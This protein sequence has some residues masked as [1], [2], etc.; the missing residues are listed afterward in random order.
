MNLPEDQA[1][2]IDQQLDRLFEKLEEFDDRCLFRSARQVATEISRLARSE[3]RLL[4]YLRS[5]F[6]LMNLAQST[7]EPELGRDVALELIALLESEERARQFQPNFPEAGYFE[8][9]AW[10]SACAYDNLAKHTATIQGYNSEGMHSCIGE[11]IQV[12]RRTGKLRCIT[13]FREYATDVYQ[14]ADD[15]DMALHYARL[16]ASLPKDAPGSERRWVGAKDET[17]LLTLSAQLP[18]AEAAGR[19]ALTLAESYH[20][21]LSAQLETLVLLETIFLL[22]GKYDRFTSEI[23]V[24]PSTRELP[25]GE[26]P[27]QEVSWDQ[28]DALLACCRGDYNE[29]I[30]L[31]SHWDRWLNERHCQ[32]DWF[33]IRLRLI[34]TFRL[35]GQDGKLDALA[36]LLETR[37]RKAC[38]WLTLRRLERLLDPNE[39]AT[40]LAL[41]APLTRGPFA[42][43]GRPAE[44]SA[45]TPAPAGPDQPPETQPQPT[46]L[47]E[48][49]SE[50]A[51]RLDQAGEDESARAAILDDFLALDSAAVTHPLDAARLLHLVRYTLGDYQRGEE[52]W[53]W[54]Q[55]I[56]APFAQQPTVVSLLATL[57]DM[58]RSGPNELL[59]TQI[60]PTRLEQL[61]RQSLDL[62]K[63]DPGNYARAGLFYLGQED[64]GE[65]ERCL[66]RSFRLVRSNGPIALRLAEVYKQTDRPR[67]ALAVLDLCL[68]EGSEDAQVA[69]D[70]ALIAFH[71]EQYDALLTYLDRFEQLDPGQPWTNYYRATGLLEVGK[72]EEA[73]KALDEEERR[74]PDCPFPV[75]LLRACAASALRQTEEFRTLLEKVLATRWV[76]V[77]YLTVAGLASLCARLWKASACLPTD[78]PLRDA[79]VERLLSAG[80]APDD[81]L[82]AERQK[83][84]EAE[85]VNFY[86]CVVVQPLD[87]SWPNWSGCLAGQQEWENYRVLWGVLARDEDEAAQWVLR[88]QERCYPWPAQVEQVELDGEGY[89]DKPGVVWQGPRWSEEKEEA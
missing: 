50:L 85:N 35:A 27:G 75:V 77:N 72:P 66:A 26:Y 3:Q 30:R 12:C 40:P 32:H 54:A 2:D 58:L 56:A 88:W 36:R 70:A 16:V 34:A 87:E 42:A 48:A 8:T 49:I 84:D 43:P 41:L 64:L 6:R 53:M 18:A 29:A 28:R 31:L 20:A 46:P 71:L 61:F 4:P 65:A 7:F 33:E 59:A 74:N 52:I 78:D 22:A 60:D 47:E 55:S 9:V 89:R 38:D 81:L 44:T 63:D 45:A 5:Q 51:G 1:P 24:P 37:A 17:R 15:I 62:D 11:G 25:S 73:L 21:P 23:G 83:G 69:W 39:P 80:V 79:L 82:E 68:R 14:S 19:R 57:G 76:E 86:R 10:M 67:D 13:C